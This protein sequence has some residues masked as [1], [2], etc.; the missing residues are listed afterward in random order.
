MECWED[1][2]AAFATP[3]IPNWV[4]L[5]LVSRVIALGLDSQY[6]KIRRIPAVS[7]FATSGERDRLL[8]KLSGFILSPCLY[9]LS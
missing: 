4:C 1:H 7:G 3:V 6:C 9:K 8:T 5:F 2:A